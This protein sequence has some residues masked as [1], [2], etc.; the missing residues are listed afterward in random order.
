VLD[1]LDRDESRESHGSTPTF[2]GAREAYNG[3][4]VLPVETRPALTVELVKGMK[5]RMRIRDDMEYGE[6]DTACSRD[7]WVVGDDIW[8]LRDASLKFY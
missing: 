6:A 5:R 7:A 1:A 8:V 3:G 2:V 4:R